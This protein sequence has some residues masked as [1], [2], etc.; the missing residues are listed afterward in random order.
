[1][2]NSYFQTNAYPQAVECFKN[3]VAL[4][5]NDAQA[6]A[7]LAYAAA[8]I[9]DGQQALRAAVQPSSVDALCAVAVA[10]THLG[11]TAEALEHL[12]RARLIDPMH[13]RI[14]RH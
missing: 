5:P 8:L 9:G 3:A 7:N 14:G 12:D 10:L 13:P 2:G 1:L 6:W 11:R 4:M